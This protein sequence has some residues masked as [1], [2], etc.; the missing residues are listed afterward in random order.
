MNYIPDELVDIIYH[1]LNPKERRTMNTLST[2]FRTLGHN[3]KYQSLTLHRLFLTE[4]EKCIKA[5][6]ILD[7]FTNTSYIYLNRSLVETSDIINYKN[8][9]THILCSLALGRRLGSYDNNTIIRLVNG[10][11]KYKVVAEA[12]I[13]PPN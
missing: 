12:K 5:D 6:V 10:I 1:F 3:S 4:Y 2:Y 7:Y 11:S 8:T 13:V 9:K